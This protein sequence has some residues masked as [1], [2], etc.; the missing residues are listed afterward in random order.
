MHADM[1]HVHKQT[2]QVAAQRMSATYLQ[3]QAA[4]AC[5][6]PVA[7]RVCCVYGPWVSCAFMLSA[8]AGSW[9]LPPVLVLLLL[10][11]PAD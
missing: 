2:G 6:M 8:H 3:W 1:M 7:L 11:P 9:L 4:Y 5:A 10:Q